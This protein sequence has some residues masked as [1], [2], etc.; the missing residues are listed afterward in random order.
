DLGGIN[1]LRILAQE[2]LGEEREEADQIPFVGPQRVRR[3]R[4][5]AVQV[6]EPALDQGAHG[7]AAPSSFSWSI[8]TSC[9]AA[10]AANASCARSANAARLSTF[11]TR[12]G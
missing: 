8:A 6:F 10:Q 2:I 4:T 7:T 9:R 11:F 5:F 12:C 1:R 3:K